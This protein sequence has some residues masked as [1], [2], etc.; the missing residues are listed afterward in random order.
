MTYRE[1][2]CFGEKQ[3]K[4][5]GIADAEN[6]AWLLLETA[7]RIDKNFYY[8]HWE[9][10]VP[11]EQELKYGLLVKKR[12]K[13][14]P[15]QYI[16]GEQEFMG[17]SFLVNSSVLI[18]RQDTEIL[19]EE[20]LKVITPGMRVL[21]MCT[22]SG[23]VAISIAKYALGAKVT[24]ADISRE[25]IS[26]AKENARNHQAAVEFETGDMFKAVKGQFDVMVSN[27]PYISSGVIGTL[28]PEV[29]DFE[30]RLALDGGED[31]L[32]FYRILT[33]LGR[34]HLKPGGYL[35]MEIGYDQGQEVT[36]LLKRQGYGEIKVVK[37]LAGLDRVA[38]GKEGTNV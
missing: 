17:L 23:C 16:T 4:E 29:R 32:K 34:A 9:K 35:M 3:L 7:C 19:V 1:I 6:D 12:A 14:I 36:S 30:P 15:L 26:L 5:A 38:I 18:P 21:D 13:R 27:P 25:A 20:A 28:M 37:D 22:G 24:A 2:L 8:L 33:S 31:G 10:Q 11:G